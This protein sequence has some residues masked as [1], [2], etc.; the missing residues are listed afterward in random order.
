[1]EHLKLVVPNL[2]R[3][4]TFFRKNNLEVVQCVTA[5]FTRDGRDTDRSLGLPVI[6]H[7]SKW[8]EVLDELKPEPNELLLVKQT[9]GMFSGT[10]AYYV[11][12][13]MEIDYLAFGDMVSDGSK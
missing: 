10:N 9:A 12:K 1:M 13:H 6:P 8:A 3:L 11:L 5:S 2:Q 4:Q 7:N